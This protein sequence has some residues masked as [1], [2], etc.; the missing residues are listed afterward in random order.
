M[1][2]GNILCDTSVKT[3][4]TLTEAGYFGYLLVFNC[5]GAFTQTYDLVKR[6]LSDCSNSGT[7]VLIDT[8]RHFSKI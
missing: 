1:N 3:L 7:S 8:D 6:N 4:K 2:V 5:Y